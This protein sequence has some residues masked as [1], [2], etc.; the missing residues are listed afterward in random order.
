MKAGKKKGKKAR[1]SSFLNRELSWLEFNQRVLD[2]ALDPAVP[3]LERVKFLA[4]TGS[5]LDEF[6]MVRVG[7]LDLVVEQGGTGRDPSGLT[8][9]EQLD[10]IGRRVERMVA[11]QYRLYREDLEPALARAGIR[12]LRMDRLG[13]DQ[14]A[15]L[16]RLFES[17]VYPVL[18]P[19][20]VGEGVEF[21]LLAGL[22]CHILVRLAPAEPGG[23]DDF[24]VIPVAGRSA[25]F[26]AVP[27][28]SGHAYV[29]L[30]D[31]VRSRAGSFFHGRDVAEVTAF[32]ITRNAGLSVREDFSDDFLAA[33]ESVL[34]ER[35]RSGCVRL[36]MEA[37]ASAAARAFLC[38]S[39]DVPPE[40]VF[41]ADGPVGVAVLMRLA[42][43]EGFDKLKNRPWPPQPSP[44]IDLRRSIFEELSK[45]PVLLYHPYESFEPV[46]R[47]VDEASRDPDVLSIKQ[48]LYRTSADSPVIAALR[49]AAANGKAVTALVEL[50]ARFDE[51]R[52]IAWAKDLER[53]GAQ[54]IYGVK[55]LKTHAKVCVVLRREPHGMV[56]YTHFGTGNYNEKTAAL[57]GDVSYMSRDDELGADASA[58]FNAVCGYS[59][60]GEFRKIAVAPIGLR[61]RLLEL[62][63]S[64]TERARRGQ[65]ALIMAKLNSLV[66]PQIISALC[67]A[68][69]AGVDVRLNVRGICCLKP[70]SAGPGGNITVVSIVDR[71]LEHARIF[72][73]LQGGEERVFISSA[74][75]M[76]RNLDKRVELMTPIEDT[77]CRNRAI[78]ILETH[79]ADNE[80]AH[81]LKGDGSYAR[82]VRG[83]GEQRLRSQEALFAMACEAVAQARARK[84]TSFEPHVPPSDEA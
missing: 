34:D 75:W 15:Y 16:A 24:A 55:G 33:M 17:E 44:R 40:R 25:R 6:F 67:D 59:Q 49:R 72:R 39:L 28:S 35:K 4:I 82:V 38:A 18:T 29:L 7:G 32:R 61:E 51:A 14:E 76:P 71:Y 78:A 31:L 13:A 74:D 66:D 3:L 47:L 54:V 57:Y 1:E 70:G 69:G 62:I 79:F 23:A 63:A 46:L 50:K 19:M 80:K 27:V 42:S 41:E 73:F 56:R 36:E 9:V 2:E 30:E 68:S 22:V 53:A 64:E 58:F 48:I 5:N 81:I 83:K 26:L 8:A 11:D 12:R 45:G 21:P 37:G 84:P 77:A 43:A 52:N 60:P 10:L 65:K 20:A